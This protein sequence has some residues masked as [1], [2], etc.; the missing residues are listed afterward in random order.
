M[1]KRRRGKWKCIPDVGVTLH[2]QVVEVVGALSSTEVRALQSLDD[3]SLHHPGY[4]SGQQGQQE[5]LLETRTEGN[6]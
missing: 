3:L 2:I 6:Q 5:T 1:V 4:V